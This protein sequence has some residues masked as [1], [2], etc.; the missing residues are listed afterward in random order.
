MVGF[1]RRTFMVPIPAAPDIEALNAML[2]ERCL[3]RQNATLRGA[4]GMIGERLAAD[5]AAFSDLPPTPFDACDKRPGKASSQAPP[6]GDAK[7]RLPVSG[8]A[9]SAP[10]TRSRSPTRIAMCW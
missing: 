4:D 10:T 7:H 2:L 1:G 9:T 3:T 5:R 6:L 8:C